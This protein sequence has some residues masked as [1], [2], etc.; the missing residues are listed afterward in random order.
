MKKLTVFDSPAYGRDTK[1]I[2]KCNLQ[3]FLPTVRLLAQTLGSVLEGNHN[4]SWKEKMKSFSL[5]ILPYLRGFAK[6]MASKDHVECI[7]TNARRIGAKKAMR[8]L[9]KKD[10]IEKI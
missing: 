1:T 7:F 10:G 8:G 2:D 9:L 5:Y 3:D 4:T 6:T